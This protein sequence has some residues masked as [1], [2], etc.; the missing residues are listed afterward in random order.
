MRGYDVVSVLL[1]ENQ[2]YQ[3]H[4]Y[5]TDYFSQYNVPVTAFFPPPARPHS[6]STQSSRQSQERDERSMQKYYVHASSTSEARNLVKHLDWYHYE[7]LNSLRSYPKRAAKTFW[8]PFVQHKSIKSAGDITVIDSAHGDLF[9]C[10]SPPPSSTVSTSNSNSTSSTVSKLPLLHPKFDGSASWWT[11]GFGHASSALTSA[12][13]YAAGRYG[14]VIFPQ[15][16]HEPALQLA[17]K[18]LSTQG[19]G[20]ASRVFF[21]DNGSTGV[22]VAL[23]MALRATASLYSASESAEMGGTKEKVDLK[24][25]GLKGSYHGDTIG[26]MDACEGGVYNNTV[27]WYRG[28]GYW[29]DSPTL[30]WEDGT[31][32]VRIPWNDKV[33][34]IPSL[35]VAYD[36][37]NRRGTS[38]EDIYRD[39]I[40][41]EITKALEAGNRFGALVMEPLVLGAGGMQF[42][43]PLFQAILVEV[44]RGMSSYLLPPGPTVPSSVQTLP[45]VYDEV[46]TGLGRLGFFSASQI[47]G[48]KPDIAV[49]AKL[50]TGGLVP[51]AV[52]LA[53]EQ[54]FECFVGEEKRK[55]LLHGHSY[56]AY[57]VGC[58]VANAALRETENV[59]KGEE[60]SKARF[61]WANEDKM[62]T[63]INSTAVGNEIPGSLWSFN[64]TQA[65]SRAPGIRRVMTLGTVLAFE[66]DNTPQGILFTLLRYLSVDDFDRLRILRRRA[67]TSLPQTS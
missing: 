13:A 67:R 18:M 15:V 9:T 40:I 48:V 1:F 25:L 50:L 56:T 51:L 12:A 17:E 33:F 36:V 39:Y 4:N 52:T 44:V 19:D 37:Y 53:T 28:R 32:R 21:S 45:I 10:F 61:S 22:E 29:L 26:A 5:L 20:W 34:D 42:I 41:S 35:G 27:E 46:F 23:K 43:D 7:R 6:D 62:D 54:I 49:Y 3:N 63:F 31:L 64:F 2:R 59:L 14:H 58:E 57:P 11:Q 24:V 55:A 30:G 47:L 8:Y 60:W 38:L 16:V 66:L 65:L